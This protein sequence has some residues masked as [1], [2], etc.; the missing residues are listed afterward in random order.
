MSTSTK[1]GHSGFRHPPLPS[2]LSTPL[3][4]PPSTHTFPPHRF[5]PPAL[6]N[7]N[8][9]AATD[10][11]ETQRPHRHKRTEPP[12]LIFFEVL[13]GLVGLGI[14]VGCSRCCYIYTKTPKRDRIEA[15]LERHRLEQELAELER[16][17][18]ALRREPTPLPVY[19][20][21]PPTYDNVTQ[22]V[23]AP[24]PTRP[25]GYAEVATASPPSSRPASPTA[26]PSLPT[27]EL[28]SGS[29]DPSIPRPTI[30]LSP[31]G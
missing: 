15:I 2:R 22:S 24:T 26:A 16:N 21:P 6:P 10:S 18:L 23:L 17:P 27:Q 7:P 3:L 28:Q 5:T 25:S 13:G 20:P 11:L 9:P 14:I 29:P 30:P 19:F 31:N 12:I 8:T 4:H 1:T